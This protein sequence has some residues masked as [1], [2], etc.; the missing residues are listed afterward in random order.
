MCVNTAAGSRCLA[1]E[2]S[3]P[4]CLR[5][6]A[7]TRRNIPDLPGVWD[8]TELL[9][10]VS[11]LR[12]SGRYTAATSSTTNMIYPLSWLSEYTDL[13]TDEKILT[14][15]LTMIG[16][17]LDKKTQVGKETVIDLELRG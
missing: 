7:W 12:T 4:I 14:D 13:P 15:K 11:E 2:W 1:P 5:L 17:M 3:T 6:S 9:W 8:R 16:H 10:I